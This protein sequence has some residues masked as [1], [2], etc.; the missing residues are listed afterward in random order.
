MIEVSRLNGK[1]YV[2]N[3]DLIKTIEA[4]PDTIITLNTNEKLMVRES[5]NEIIDKTIC[6]KKKIFFGIPE[7]IKE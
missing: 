6:Y 7:V 2:L 4:T 5:V 3:C 1:S